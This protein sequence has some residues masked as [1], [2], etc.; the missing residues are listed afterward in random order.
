[1]SKLKTKRTNEMTDD[2]I[3]S[4]SKRLWDNFWRTQKQQ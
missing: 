3:F 1:M 2:V 4:L